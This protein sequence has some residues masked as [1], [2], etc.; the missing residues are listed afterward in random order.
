LNRN[1]IERFEG[2]KSRPILYEAYVNNV[3]TFETVS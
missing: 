2:E 1:E 3:P